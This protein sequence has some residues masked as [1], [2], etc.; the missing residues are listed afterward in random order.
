LP[1][2]DAALSGVVLDDGRILVAL[3]DIES[4]RDQLSLVASHDGGVTWKT[5]IR[6]E[7]QTGFRGQLLDRARYLETTGT[8]A[9][10]SDAT[11]PDPADYA[12]S[13]G[14]QMCRGAGC[15][16][17]FSYPYLIQARNGEFHLAYTW[18]RSFIKHVR[19][20]QA[21]LDRR[22]SETGN[23]QRH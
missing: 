4:G 10:S 18:N 11:V 16:F 7:D 1:N 14:V 22:L 20:N 15:A 8:L 23:D 17:E 19:F 3:N 13:A 9:R 6:L 2:P 21:W 12:R 5:V